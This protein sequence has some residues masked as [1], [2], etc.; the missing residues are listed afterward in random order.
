MEDV[1]NV[2]FHLLIP[3]RVTRCYTGDGWWFITSQ[4]TPVAI[5]MFL[6]AVAQSY[7]VIRKLLQE[8]VQPP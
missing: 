5:Q 4:D 7:S 1:V 3:F 2:F 6:T 8:I